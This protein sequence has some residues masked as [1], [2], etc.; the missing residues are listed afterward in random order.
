VFLRIV[1]GLLGKLLTH[2]WS[3]RSEPEGSRELLFYLL[4]PG[5]TTWHQ[6]RG[7][8]NKQT[9]RIVRVAIVQ[10]SAFL[11]MAPALLR[12]KSFTKV[13]VGGGT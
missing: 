1:T 5:W 6:V 8:L 10:L 13:C 9:K 2:S 4:G 12:M 7:E 3:F 11:D